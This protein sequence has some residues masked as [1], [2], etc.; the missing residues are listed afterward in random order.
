[1][2]LPPGHT[3]RVGAGR[4]HRTALTTGEASACE[5]TVMSANRQRGRAGLGGARRVA[6]VAAAG[7]VTSLLVAGPAQA[8]DTYYVSGPNLALA[9]NGGHVEVS[10]QM[11]G[12]PASA[13]NDGI[14]QTR[15][16]YWNDATNGQ[17]PDW[18]Q[19]VWS[20]PITVSEVAL[21]MPIADQLTTPQRTPSQ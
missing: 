13:L 8:D 11:A 18:A 15:A 14:R 6:V 3:V 21:R 16:G 5:G 9:A 10:S 2:V 1:M 19:V 12:Y 7:L 20:E 4:L 17:F